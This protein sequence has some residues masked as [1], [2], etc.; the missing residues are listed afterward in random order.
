MRLPMRTPI[1]MS[2]PPPTPDST[3]PTAAGPE[4]VV[5]VGLQSS[6]NG[7]TP[8]PPATRRL[9]AGPC[10]GAGPNARHREARQRRLVAE[11]LDAGAS[12]VVDNTNPSLEDRAALIAA[13]QR[14][15]ARVRAV[16]VD[17]PVEVCIERN[18]DREGRARVPLVGLLDTRGRLVPPTPDEGFD[19]IDVVRPAG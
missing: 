11:L 1:R 15:G 13:A 16:W 12:V 10:T 19:R 7:R 18:R 5:M 3:E 4:L 2:T 14:A 17:T 6:G 9:A 8:V